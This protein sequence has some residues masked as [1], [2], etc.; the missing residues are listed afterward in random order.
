[1]S[2]R[3]RGKAPQT[4]PPTFLPPLKPCP[5]LFA[6]L[7]GVLLVW[8]ALLVTL[9]FTTVVPR[10]RHPTLPTTHASSIE[11]TPS[12]LGFVLHA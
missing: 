10:E 2:K 9:Y 6:V 3:Q 7:M 4:A 8:I 11:T 5:R 12:A 1:M